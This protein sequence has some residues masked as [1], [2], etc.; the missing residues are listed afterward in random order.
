MGIK[1]EFTSSDH[2]R[3]TDRESQIALLLAEG[4]SDKAISALLAISIKTVSAHTQ[5]IY[6][7]LGVHS[8]QLNARYAAIGKLIASGIIRLSLNSLV[9]LLVFGAMQID[10]GA[11]KVKSTRARFHLERARRLSDA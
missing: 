6:E 10:D 5:M 11:L 7:K 2:D 9:A 4:Y 3:L 1:A 8:H